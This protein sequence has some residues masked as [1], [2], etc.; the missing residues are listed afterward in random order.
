M[1][2]KKEPA[3]RLPVLPLSAAI[4]AALAVAPAQAQST[5]DSAG[6]MPVTGNVPALC[7]GGA[8]TGTG[9]FDLGVLTEPTNGLLRNDLSAP[10]KTLGG[11]FCSARSRLSITATPLESENNAA[12]PPAGYSRT[13]NYTATA[14]GWTASPASFTTGAASNPGS[15]QDRA[16]AFQGDIT[17]AI[18][19]FGTG[20]GDALR[21]VADP[22]YRGHVTVTLSVAE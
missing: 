19:G 20:G 7:F 9:S 22:S 2:R 17:V 8:L 11:A 15:S 13:V 5:S 12:T 3:M 21:L 16:T 6:P 18:G 10:S 1:S 14:S 4:A